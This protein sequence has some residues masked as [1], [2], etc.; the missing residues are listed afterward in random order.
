MDKKIPKIKRE[1]V[2]DKDNDVSNSSS[3][4]ITQAF[5]PSKTLQIRY[6]GMLSLKKTFYLGN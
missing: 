3:I 6:F 2:P 4:S 1:K 5:N